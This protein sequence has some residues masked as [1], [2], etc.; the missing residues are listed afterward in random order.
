MWAEV[1][2]EVVWVECFL[3]E[4]WEEEWVEVWPDVVSEDSLLSVEGM[5]A[6]LE[7]HDP[8]IGS[9]SLLLLFLSLSSLL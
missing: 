4:V 7:P 6:A 2:A 1:W 8:I 5:S 3:A 9:L